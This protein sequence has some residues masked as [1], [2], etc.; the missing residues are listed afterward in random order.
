VLLSADTVDEVLPAPDR[1]PAGRV[2]EPAVVVEAERP[3]FPA[4]AEGVPL[5][6]ARLS[7]SALESYKRCGYRFYLERVVKMR[8]AAGQLAGNVEAAA[9]DDAGDQLALTPSAVAPDEMSPLVRGTIVHELLERVDFRRPRSPSPAEIERQMVANGASATDDK[10]AGIASLIEGFL[11]SDLFARIRGA[12]RVRQE[13]PF[14]YPL[15]PD[16]LGGRSLLVNGVVDVHAEFGDHLLVVDYKTDALEGRDPEEV[17]DE[18]YAGQRLVYALAGLRSDAPEVEVAYCFLER[19]DLVVS[20]RFAAGERAQLEDELLGLA[21]GVIS[22]RFVPAAEPH[23]ELCQSCP[24]QS[25]LCSW[26]PDRTLA[27]RPEGETFAAPEPERQL[28]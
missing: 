22:G 11:A 3:H 23:R 6:V 4:L 28:S 21:A 25:A 20:R 12:R 24:G 15:E 7:Y 8:R 17:C 2:A 1:A 16:G 14:A 5:P 26:P 9:P 10:L 13:L 27:E 19:P 18:K